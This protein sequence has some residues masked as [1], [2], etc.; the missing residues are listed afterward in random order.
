MKGLRLEHVKDHKPLPFLF[1]KELLLFTK[2]PIENPKG[3]MKNLIPI[4][5]TIA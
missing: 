5:L 1:P 2:R 3:E 4:V